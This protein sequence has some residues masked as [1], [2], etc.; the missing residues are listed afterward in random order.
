[1]TKYKKRIWNRESM[2]L[3][4]SVLSLFNIVLLKNVSSYSILKTRTL[5]SFGIEFHR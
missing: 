5:I 2:H 3:Q 1:M 4:I